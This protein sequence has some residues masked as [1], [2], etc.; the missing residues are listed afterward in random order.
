MRQL[1]LKWIWLLLLISLPAAAMEPPPAFEA[2]Y[3]LKK[4]SSTVAQMTMSLEYRDTGL[5]YHAKTEPVGLLAIFSRDRIT[6]ASQ[7]Q[8]SAQESPPRL[9]HYQLQRKN[10][11]DK[12]QRIDIN[13]NDDS[14]GTIQTQYGT[15]QSQLTH[16]GPIWDRFSVQLALRASLQAETQP[17]PGTVF[18][19]HVIDRGK[20]SNYQFEYIHSETIKQ[21]AG[22]YHTLKFLRH[23]GSRKTYLW[24]ATELDHFL[25][26][27]E[28]YKKDD[29]IMSMELDHY[30]QK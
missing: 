19:Y 25:I 9:L 5:L 3:K 7:L 26:K 20:I 4:Y 30:R 10:N 14:T 23:H 29:L 27:S 24:L 16:K 6:E 17:N 28:Q 13:W 21:T 8:W 22:N 1:C 15:Q 18:S 12:N 11:A 2:T